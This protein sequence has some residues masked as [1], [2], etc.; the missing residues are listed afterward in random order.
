MTST[1][2]QT[3]EETEQQVNDLF[4]SLGVTQAVD[5]EEFRVFLDHIPIAIVVSRV[6]RGEQ[7]LVYANR[8]YEELTGRPH[9]EIRGLEW[10]VLDSF[11]L[12]DEP[13]LTFS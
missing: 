7:R 1:D 11:R 6:V 4:D 8:A 13:H 10:S 2:G 5:T 9:A 12:E 3:A